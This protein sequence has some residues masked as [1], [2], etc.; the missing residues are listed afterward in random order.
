M[1]GSLQVEGTPAGLTQECY[2]R[3]KERKRENDTR[4]N[5]GVHVFGG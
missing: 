3:E 4:V 1:S 5:T 2:K